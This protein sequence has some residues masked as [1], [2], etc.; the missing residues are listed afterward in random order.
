VLRGQSREKEEVRFATTFT[1]GRNAECDLQILD[2]TIARAHVQ[3]VFDGMIWWT[4]DLNTEG[5]TYVNGRRVQFVPLPD[6]A[7][8]E[9][10]K[11][12]P[13]LSL[14][15][16]SE[17]AA[18]TRSRAPAGERPHAP[19]RF[20]SETQ[21]IE[22][23]V[24]PTDGEPAGRETMM[25]YRAFER[26]KKRSSRRYHLIIG[27][28]LVALV[29]SA[30]L[31]GYEAVKLRD[32]RGTAEKIFYTARSV[33][34][35]TSR[36][37]E[38]VRERGDPRQIAELAASRAKLGQMESEYD[39]F[40]RELG[41]YRVSEEERAILRVARVFG[42]CEANV[43]KEFVVEVR[44]FVERW[45]S[46]NRLAKAL[47]RAKQRGYQEAIV[48]AFTR[49]NLP[50]QFLYLA[51]QESS[52][53]ERAV[54]PLSRY[55][56]AKGMWQFISMTAH[57][58]GLK[59][60]P[61]RD[62]GV[63]DSEDERFDFEKSTAAAVRYIKHLSATDAQGSGLLVMASYNWGEGN[64]RSAIASLPENP[65]DRNFWLLLATKKVPRETYDYVLSIFSAAV[66]CE[67][68]RLFG[69][70]VECPEA[71]GGKGGNIRPVGLGER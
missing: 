19:G 12:G 11:G 60:G 71:A 42:E 40:V 52:F 63:Y 61:F 65:K 66:I 24:R 51:L 37:E 35:Q 33:E 5:G 29:V 62:R 39:A 16:E 59:V 47:S 44:R 34:V 57:Y 17:G 8:V 45:R 25:L 27:M 4:R 56:F 2:D 13:L 38:L 6:L 41:V 48:R 9:L 43:P 68:P 21:I 26:V 18:G 67:N 70:D 23:R 20:E 58:Y 50:A 46:T 54:G 1:V 64:V 10:G 22:R 7:E 3:V 55:G 49:S 31:V 32:L 30:T 14:T 15:L 36:L 69:F 53:D 28:V